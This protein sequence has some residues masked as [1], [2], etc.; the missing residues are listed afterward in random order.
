MRN[1]ARFSAMIII[2]ALPL[3]SRPWAPGS[4]EGTEIRV[5][6]AAEGR[7]AGGRPLE[8][9]GRGVGR[10][11]PLDVVLVAGERFVQHGDGTVTDTKRRIMWQTGDNGK[12]VTFGEAQAYCK[13]LRLAGYDD[14]RLPN[15]D[16][17]DTAVVVTLMM[18][19]HSRDAHAHM[20]L[21]W[22]S[23]PT[24]LIPFNYRPSEGMEVSR[25]Y[26]ARE[27]ARA[28]VRAVRSTAGSPPG[29]KK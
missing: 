22:S 20:D 6:G 5:D 13:T 9:T 2:C 18:S 1:A 17:R 29:G 26:F 25:E 21:Y 24:V 8:L 11:G 19:R 15:P 27:G 16:E 28:F 3:F 7:G 4:A 14:W 23:I 12:E 10:L